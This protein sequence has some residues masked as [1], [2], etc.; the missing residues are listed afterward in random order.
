MKAKN[1]IIRLRKNNHFMS[2]A[3]IARKVGVTRQYAREVLLKNDLQTNAPKPKRVVYCKVCR[4]ITTDRGG[5]HKGECS[6]SWR[7]KKLTCSWCSVPF[8]RTRKRILQ[9][10]RLKLKNIYCTQVCYQTARKSNSG[11]QQR[12]NSKMG[13]ENQ[14]DGIQYLYTRI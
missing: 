14:Q 4:D 10:Y 8:Y 13:T 6:F 12:F 2:T 1:K 5:I 11:D 9:G 7:F 3:D